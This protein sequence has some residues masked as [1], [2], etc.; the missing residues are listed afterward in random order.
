MVRQNDSEIC[1]VTLIVCF[2]QPQHFFYALGI[3]LFFFMGRH[4]AEA[5]VEEKHW[6]QPPSAFVRVLLCD[7]RQ[8]LQNYV[9][10]LRVLV[11]DQP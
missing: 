6:V 1:R 5:V 2:V 9:T 3:L 4:P 8:N 7:Q 11:R 10:K